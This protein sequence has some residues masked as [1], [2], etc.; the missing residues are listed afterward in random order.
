MKS[1][2]RKKSIVLCLLL[3]VVAGV[4]R[5]DILS[6]SEYQVTSSS[7]FET[8]PSLGSDGSSDLVVYTSRALLSTSFFDQRDIWYQR[9]AQKLRIT[10]KRQEKVEV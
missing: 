6:V 3:V 1:L 7:A 10:A 5:A 8:T 2:K 4:T 9:L